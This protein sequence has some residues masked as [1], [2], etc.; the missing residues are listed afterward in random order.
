MTAK[1]GRIQAHYLARHRL[2]FAGV[3]LQ[4]L[5]PVCEAQNPLPKIQ[6][7]PDQHSDHD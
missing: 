4:Q 1:T 2:N 6:S 7:L 5:F 3:L